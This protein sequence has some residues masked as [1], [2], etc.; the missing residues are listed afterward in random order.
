MTPQTGMQIGSVVT[1]NGVVWAV[2][3]EGD[4]VLESGAPVYRGESIVTGRNAN[5]EIQFQD[6]TLLG[7]GQEARV[8]LDEY[9]F[10]GESGGLDFQMV[11]GVMRLVSG[12]IAE[13]NPEAFNLSTPLATIGIRGTEIIAKINVDGQVVGVTDMSPGHYV[14]VA[15]P[16]G[17]VRIEAPGLF[18]G[19]DADG[20]LTQVQ[21]LPQD[22][23]D[24]VQ[25]AVPLT[26]MGDSPRDPDDPPPDVQDP[27]P[28]GTEPGGPDGEPEPAGEP[29]PGGDDPPPQGV[30]PP[31]PPPPPPLPPSS[32]AGAFD[33]ADFVPPDTTPEPPSDDTVQIPDETVPGG[34]SGG[35]VWVDQSGNASEHC[36]T[37]FGDTLSGMDMNDTLYGIQGDDYLLG[38]DGNDDLFGE[39]DNDTLQGD[40]GLDYLVGG[41]GNDSL[42]GGAGDDILAGGAGIDT[43]SGG[44][45]NDTFT[46]S[47]TTDGIDSIVDMHAA[48]GGG[49]MISLS[50]VGANAFGSL[51]W[52]GNNLSSYSF[53]FVQS[54]DYDGTGVDFDSGETKGIVYASDSGSTSGKLYYDP[55]DTQAGDEILL[56]TVTETDDD[57]NPQDNDITSSDI[58]G[59]VVR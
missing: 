59:D 16:D 40:A 57:G 46:I 38:G 22:F 49:D 55:D 20:F 19:V 15:T 1:L 21:T 54:S 37:E 23:I 5:V 50:K 26:T 2:T 30:E 31:P 51:R 39:C 7:Q 32:D 6:G 58:V 52:E 3:S 9:V 34:E 4:R 53:A 18:A 13:T 47:S 43:M 45:G 44:T 8:D 11:K 24:A 17:E 33:P 14:V 42:V 10:D 29:M 25:A 48:C 41:N 56:A 27:V 36:G 28:G 12:K 35:E